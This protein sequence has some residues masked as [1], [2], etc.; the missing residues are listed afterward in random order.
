MGSPPPDPELLETSR[1]L[2]AESRR[3]RAELDAVWREHLRGRERVNDHC[4]A[5]LREARPRL[6]ARETVRAE[7]AHRAIDWLF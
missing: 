5:F 4:L 3:V 7:R 2:I 6:D 1:A